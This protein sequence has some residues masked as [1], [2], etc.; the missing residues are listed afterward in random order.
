MVAGPSPGWVPRQLPFR[1]ALKGEAPQS[2][3]AQSSAPF[4]LRDQHEKLLNVSVRGLHAD[5]ADDGAYPSDT[6]LRLIPV[7][8]G[9]AACGVTIKVFAARLLGFC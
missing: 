9:L 5:T 1:G 8:P 4:N 3:R 7:H 2:G 6:S